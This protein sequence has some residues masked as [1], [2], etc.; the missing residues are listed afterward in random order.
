M[1]TELVAYAAIPYLLATFLLLPVFGFAIV[2]VVR[3]MIDGDLTFGQGLLSITLLLGLLAFG[4]K[5]PY[6]AAPWVV[7]GVMVTLMAFFPFAETQL[8]KND[9]RLSNAEQID[10]AHAALSA[11]PD[12]IPAAFLLARTVYDHGY[13]GHGIALAEGVLSQLSTTQDPIKLTSA[14]DH[15]RAEEMLLQKWKRESTDPRDFAPLKCPLCG[16]MNPPGPLA[17]VGCGKAYILEAARQTDSQKRVV[18]KLV[19]GWAVIALAM[20][21]GA[22]CLMSFRPPLNYVGLGISLVLAGLVVAALFRPRY[23]DNTSPGR[24][25]S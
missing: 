1:T 10:R 12:N 21:A 24:S 2:C 8:G 23:G 11:R 20:T 19:L 22:S 9:M 13:R 3:W 4:I 25:F 6:P 16:R 15:F 14:R 7:A 5:A 17:C 18:G